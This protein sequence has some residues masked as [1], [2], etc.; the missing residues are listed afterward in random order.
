MNLTY[1]ICWTPY[2]VIAVIHCFVSKTII[3]PMVSIIPVVAV[4]ISVCAN[5]L[6]YIAYNPKLNKQFE[7]NDF[8]PD[9]SDKDSLEFSLPSLK[10]ILKEIQTKHVNMQFQAT[11]EMC[12]E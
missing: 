7:T 1:L 6:L 12:I 3:G 9:N 10:S 8:S 4:K 5:P 11:D 2:V